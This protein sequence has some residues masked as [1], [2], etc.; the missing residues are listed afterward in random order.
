MVAQK[1]LKLQSRCTAS[2]ESVRRTL[3]REQ[4]KNNCVQSRSHTWAKLIMEKPHLC[5]LCLFWTCVMR[6]SSR[7]SLFSAIYKVTWSQTWQLHHFVC[8]SNW[9]RR[10]I[11][12]I[13]HA[14]KCHPVD[15]AVCQAAFQCHPAAVGA[16]L[17]LTHVS[18]CCCLVSGNHRA[19]YTDFSFIINYLRI[20]FVASVV[21]PSHCQP[22]YW[23]TKEDTV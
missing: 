5:E 13:W 8:K 21:W 14:W 23:R 4:N 3:Q 10:K 18:L 2:R 11:H 12:W 15:S 19:E 6:V 7:A 16:P 9:E 20:A 1:C 17:I 22:A